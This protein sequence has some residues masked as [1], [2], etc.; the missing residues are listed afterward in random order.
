[1][2]W[3]HFH[4]TN[5]EKTRDVLHKLFQTF[6]TNEK[7]RNCQGDGQIPLLSPVHVKCTSKEKKS[8]SC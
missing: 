3:K 4:Y 2:F 7:A 5:I 8:V 1:M 6:L